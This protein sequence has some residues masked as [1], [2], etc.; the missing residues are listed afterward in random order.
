VAS[1]RLIVE[2]EGGFHERRQVADARR[3]RELHRLGYAVLHLDAELV[4]RQLPV[5]VATVRAAVAS[6]NS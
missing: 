3:D 5:A 4:L 1:L 6:G 2:V